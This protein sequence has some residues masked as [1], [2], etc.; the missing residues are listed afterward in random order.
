M[1]C[2]QRDI[3][4]AHGKGQ[5]DRFEGRGDPPANWFH[6]PLAPY[7]DDLARLQEAYDAGYEHGRSQR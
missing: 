4:E 5:K 2:D 6:G 1:A 7:S 3:D